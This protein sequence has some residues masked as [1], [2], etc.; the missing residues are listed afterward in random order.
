MLRKHSGKAKRKR[1][2]TKYPG[3]VRDATELG[4]SRIHLWFVLTKVRN[5]RPLMARYTALKSQQRKQVAFHPKP[6]A[7]PH[8][9]P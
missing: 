9:K 2:P 1:G 6:L 5:S 7:I 4:V 3:I 8:F